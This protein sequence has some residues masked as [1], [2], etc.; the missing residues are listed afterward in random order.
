[1]ITE[2]V[3]LLSWC[4]QWLVVFCR[5]G[6]IFIP[7]FTSYLHFT[8]KRRKVTD[9]DAEIVP[10]SSAVFYPFEIFIAKSLTLGAIGKWRIIVL[11]IGSGFLPCAMS[12]VCQL[13][14]LEVIACVSLNCMFCVLFC[15][16]NTLHWREESV[17]CW[18]TRY[19]GTSLLVL[20]C[21][22]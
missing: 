13:H 3:L 11:I 1:M 19:L 22:S 6:P 2:P 4:I 21:V 18:Q 12:S 9:D 14:N 7:L 10:T 15:G 16:R 20:P 5:F 8:Q 17:A